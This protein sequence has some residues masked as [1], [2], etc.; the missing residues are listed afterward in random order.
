MPM[1]DYVWLCM[2]MYGYVWLCMTIYDYVWQ[3]WLCMT[4]YNKVWLLMTNFLYMK[5][6]DSEWLCIIIHNQKLYFFIDVVFNEILNN[7]RDFPKKMIENVK[8]S[9]DILIW[10][11]NLGFA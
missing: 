1:Y 3:E 2:T 9:K 10:L 5:L 7:I 8:T 6:Y 4:M 11:L